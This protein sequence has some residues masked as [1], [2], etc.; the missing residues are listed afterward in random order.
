MQAAS[1]PAPGC[2]LPISRSSYW[3]LSPRAWRK[4]PR[5][6]SRDW[7]EIR[8][9]LEVEAG[10]PDPREWEEIMEW[11]PALWE[12]DWSIKLRACDSGDFDGP[13]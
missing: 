9:C 6:T 7:D 8:A 4:R 3:E 1:G 12:P 2:P 13:Q 5:T 11:A 10:L